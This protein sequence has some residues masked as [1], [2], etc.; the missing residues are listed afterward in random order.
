MN[1]IN[2]N[3]LFSGAGNPD[4]IAYPGIAVMLVGLAMNL[5]ARKLS[6]F[7]GEA[8]EAKVYMIVRLAAVVVVAVGALITMKLI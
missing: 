6:G 3:D 2:W 1:I 7:A 5:F 8:H 4:R